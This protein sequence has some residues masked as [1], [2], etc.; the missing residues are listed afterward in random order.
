VAFIE[1]PRLLL[2]PLSVE[3][4]SD[5]Y[6]A[7]LNDPEVLRFRGPK[8]FPSTMV[9]LRAYLESIPARGDLVLAL[10]LKD[11]A[12]HVGNIALNSILWVHGTAELSMMIGARDVWGKKLGQEAIAGVT[13]HAFANMRLHRLWAES[14]NPAFNGAVKALGWTCEGIKRQAFLVDGRHVDVECWG[15]LCEEHAGAAAGR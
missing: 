5:E 9:S 10:R 4:A 14:P 1:T 13:T 11:G 8:A 6:L 15:I 7:W 3:D 12:R 2:T